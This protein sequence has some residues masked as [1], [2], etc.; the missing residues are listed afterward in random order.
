MRVSFS[1]LI[2]SIVLSTLCLL[3]S[4]VSCFSFCFLCE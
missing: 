1:F 3:G 2:T 4:G